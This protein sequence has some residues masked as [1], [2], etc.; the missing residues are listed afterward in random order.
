MPLMPK[1]F[2]RK[3][4]PALRSHSMGLV[5]LGMTTFYRFLIPI[6]FLQTVTYVTDIGES[7]EL[8]THQRNEIRCR[9][10]GKSVSAVD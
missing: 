2:A 10:I 6:Y 1:R 8:P 4:C 3:A 5:F 7:C 9:R